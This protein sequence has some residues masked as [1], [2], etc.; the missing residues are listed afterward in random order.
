MFSNPLKNV[1]ALGL[2]ED[3]IVVDL[4]A[5]MGHYALISASIVER[6]KVYAIDLHKDFLKTVENKA[7][8]AHIKNIECI[9][10]NAEV[11]GGTKLKDSIVDA[12]IVS[13]ILF[14][15]EDRENFILE[16]KRILKAGGRVL[17]ID[18]SLPTIV[19]AKDLVPKSKA[20]EMF[21]KAGFVF[22]REIDAGAYHYGMILNK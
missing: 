16:I 1:K 13:N 8:E 18:W 14:Q 3:S 6:G 22:E 12:V 15:I 17:L 2:R 20:R 4:G 9:V 10:G 11:K 7:K 21:E 5:G 19:R